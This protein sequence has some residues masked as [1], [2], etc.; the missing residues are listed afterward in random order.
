MPDPLPPPLPLGAPVRL[1]LADAGHAL[2]LAARVPDAQGKPFL[3]PARAVSLALAIACRVA[4][5]GDLD[6]YPAPATVSLCDDLSAPDPKAV[7]EW[8]LRRPAPTAPAPATVYRGR[9]RRR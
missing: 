1:S 4:E 8:L 6:R 7:A 2:R 9:K 3:T 5:A